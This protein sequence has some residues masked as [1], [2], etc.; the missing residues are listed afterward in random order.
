[1]LAG[2]LRW[3]LVVEA[4]A[5]GALAAAAGAS[6]LVDLSL[7]RLPVA[8]L[9]GLPLL[10][11][12]VTLLTYAIMWVYRS[13]HPGAPTAP[14]RPL[15][16]L[17]A[18]LA[19]WLAGFALF[20]VVQPF[21][22]WWLGDDGPI[23]ATDPQRPVVVL[24]HGYFC[25][26]GL[27]WWLRRSLIAA[28]RQ[29][30]T[31]NLEPPHGGID[32]FADALHARIEAL[33]PV[34]G[35]VILVGHS[36]GGIVARAYLARHG[37]RRIARLVTLGSPHHGTALAKLGLGRCAR[38]LEP[39]SAFIERLCSNPPH[40]SQIVSVWSAD[41][42]FLLP[43]ETASLPGARTIRVDGMGHLTMAFSTRVRDVLLAETA[44]REPG[45]P[46]GGSRA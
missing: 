9:V 46:T 38:E 37:E 6:R 2:W 18:V 28:G 10:Y 31:I 16:A 44:P 7:W 17:K 45:T 21:E 1:M 23:A 5:V 25:N 4:L 12:P 14:A 15:A 13:R 40:A 19:E 33:R 43:A 42:N 8:W 30:A 22:R 24:V 39:G 34:D 26:R 41:D 36:M 32:G 20:A 11:L 29:V 35:S 3:A 27:W